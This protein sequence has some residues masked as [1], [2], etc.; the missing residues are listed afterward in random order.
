MHNNIFVFSKFSTDFKDLEALLNIKMNKLSLFGLKKVETAIKYQY[1]RNV[2]TTT[3]PF[4]RIVWCVLGC[5][6]VSDE[7]SDIIVTA[8]DYLWLKLSRV[9][10]AGYDKDDYVDYKELQV[11][12]SSLKTVMCI[13]I[14]KIPLIYSVIVNNYNISHRSISPKAFCQM[15]PVTKI[16]FS[17][18]RAPSLR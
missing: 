2:R 12:C 13:F 8:D 17:Y 18:C 15:A 1:R 3:D 5:C 10:I 6:D 14:Y 7:H 16:H 11:R 9:R 4:K